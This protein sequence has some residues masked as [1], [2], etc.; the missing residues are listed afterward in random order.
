MRNLLVFWLTVAA[1]CD[2]V[3]ETPNED[4]NDSDDLA[5][6]KNGNRLR[7]KI[8]Q[9]ADGA[10]FVQGL[11]DTR[12]NEDCAFHTASDGKLRCLPTEIVT[13]TIYFADSS[14]TTFA[15]IVDHCLARPIKYVAVHPRACPAL[16]SEAIGVFN[17]RPGYNARDPIYSFVEG[18]CKPFTI[19]A[20]N[21]IY[22]AAEQIPPDQ[23]QVAT[24]RM[25]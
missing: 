11:Y 21:V 10:R 14:C 19:A 18:E 8:L 6:Y 17:A 22:E 15:A 13:A 9:A 24:V 7:V 1:A 5:A 2:T 12:R 25:E 16:E 3:S 4:S 20:T 23:F